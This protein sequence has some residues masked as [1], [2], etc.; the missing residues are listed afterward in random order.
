MKTGG[1]AL[2]HVG[3]GQFTWFAL[4]TEQLMEIR[5]ALAAITNPGKD[6]RELLAELWRIGIREGM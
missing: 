6:T 5:R 4:T 1:T 3:A 2:V